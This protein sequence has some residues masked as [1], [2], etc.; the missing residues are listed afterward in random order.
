M[1]CC[2]SLCLAVLISTNTDEIIE[3]LTADEQTQIASLSASKQLVIKAILSDKPIPYRKNWNGVKKGD[4]FRVKKMQVYVPGSKLGLI[5]NSS[6]VS[7]SI[8]I[9]NFLSRT[10]L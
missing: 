9:S 10:V 3:T 1:P 2:V 7:V 5:Q 6:G 4:V 8:S